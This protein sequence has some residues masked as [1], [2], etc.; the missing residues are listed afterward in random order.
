[1]EAATARGADMVFYNADPDVVFKIRAAAP[2]LCHAFDAVVTA[3]SVQKAAHCCQRPAKIATAIK[4]L[5][6]PI[7][8]VEIIPVFSGEIRGKTMTGQVSAKGQDIGCW[9]WQNV[10][11]WLD[12]SKVSP[13][14]NEE[15]G[16]L[17]AIAGGL[18]RLK[19]GT[20]KVKLVARIGYASP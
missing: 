16:G 5:G 20:A 13:L 1:M 7:E 3:E 15:I 6:E 9:L 12:E 19:D 18:Q 8:N 4:F 2:Q 11:S 10:P 14:E 17:D